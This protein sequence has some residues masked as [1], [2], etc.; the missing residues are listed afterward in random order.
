[1]IDIDFGKQPTVFRVGDRVHLKGTL[2]LYSTTGTVVQLDYQG[3]QVPS[4]A[5]SNLGVQVEWD[6][7]EPPEWW[8]NIALQPIQTDNN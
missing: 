5:P 3:D 4:P 7:G 6:S 8:N 1:M 2:V